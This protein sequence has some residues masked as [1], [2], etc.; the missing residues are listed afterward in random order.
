MHPTADRSTFGMGL[1]KAEAS[2]P[3]FQHREL[4]V[5]GDFH[6][7]IHIQRGTYRGSARI[8][9]QQSGNASADKCQLVEKRLQ[10]LGDGDESRKV[11]IF[12][13]RGHKASIL[14][15]SSRTAISRSRA[16]PSRMASTKASSS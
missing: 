10:P 1:A 4:C 7:G 14:L 2:Q 13:D 16:L 15:V 3:A 8:G 6:N 5:G 12:C 9:D 11:G